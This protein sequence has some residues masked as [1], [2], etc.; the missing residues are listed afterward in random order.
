MGYRER[1][2]GHLS[3]VLPTNEKAGNYDWH[4]KSSVYIIIYLYIYTHF[5]FFNQK[6]LI[7]LR[8]ITW[9]LWSVGITSSS[10]ANLLIGQS[11]VNQ[12]NACQLPLHSATVP[13]SLFQNWTKKNLRALASLQANTSYFKLEMTFEI[14]ILSFWS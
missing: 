2:K 9:S 6:T 5:F 13:L 4:N 7:N 10:T 8:I 14:F 11:S 1:K 12:A 3:L